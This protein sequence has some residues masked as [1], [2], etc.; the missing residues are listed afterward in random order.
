M[1]SVL[2]VGGTLIIVNRDRSALRGSTASV[3]LSCT[4]G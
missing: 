4:R 2:K 3:V 1:C